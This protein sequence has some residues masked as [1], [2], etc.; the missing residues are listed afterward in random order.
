MTDKV[1]LVGTSTE[2][3]CDADGVF[4]KNTQEIPT[5][6]LDSLAQQRNEM[7][8]KREDD[9]MRVASIPVVVVEK[10]MREGF[11]IWEATGQEIV[12]RLKDQALDGFMATN[13]RI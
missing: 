6:F 4:M 11:N 1:N 8:G 5:S 3:G 9:F 12:K 2:F 7:S 13:K 10:W